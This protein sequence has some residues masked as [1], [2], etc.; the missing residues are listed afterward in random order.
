MTLA[1]KTSRPV[2]LKSQNCSNC[3]LMVNGNGAVVSKDNQ[4]KK[5]DTH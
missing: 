1:V 3:Y 2:L 5:G 4:N